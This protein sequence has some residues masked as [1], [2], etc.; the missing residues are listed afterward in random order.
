MAEAGMRMP[1][2]GDIVLW[3]GYDGPQYVLIAEKYINEDMY[4]VIYLTGNPM[5]DDCWVLSE[6]NAVSWRIIV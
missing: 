2:V 4:K 1:Q 3:T 6:H 5:D